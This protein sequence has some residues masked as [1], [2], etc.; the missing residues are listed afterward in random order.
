M[1][2][3]PPSQILRDWPT[4]D[5]D[6]NGVFKYVLIEAYAEDEKDGQVRKFLWSRA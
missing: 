4:V 6:P 5:I 2:K 3:T 1:S